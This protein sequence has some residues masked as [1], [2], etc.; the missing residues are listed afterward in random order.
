MSIATQ[1]MESIES[2]ELTRMEVC[3]EGNREGCLQAL[4]HL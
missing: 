3:L 2:C 4:L 1:S